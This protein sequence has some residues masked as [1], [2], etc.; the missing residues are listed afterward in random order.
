MSTFANLHLL[1]RGTAMFTLLVGG[2][3][4]EECDEVDVVAS[5]YHTPAQIIVEACASTSLMDLYGPDV[6][7]WSIANQ[8]QGEL[9]F[10]AKGDVKPLSALLECAKADN[11]DG[12]NNDYIEWLEARLD[13]QIGA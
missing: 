4:K 6:L 13:A 9:V 3:T 2:R 8:S 1:P 12:R 11:H 10:D 5:V 7:V